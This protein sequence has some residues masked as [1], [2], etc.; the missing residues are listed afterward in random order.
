MFQNIGSKKKYYMAKER[1]YFY[2][3][4]EQFY[5]AIL[6]KH[7]QS[8]QSILFALYI[9]LNKKQWIW[10]KG[11]VLYLNCV[12]IYKSTFVN[13]HGILHKEYI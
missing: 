6:L 7:F 5:R 13:T 3:E 2:S 11:I 1:R 8:Y 12:A 4:Q 9:F 10:G